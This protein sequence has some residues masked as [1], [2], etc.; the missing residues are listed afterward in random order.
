VSSACS[1][2]GFPAGWTTATPGVTYWFVTEEIKREFG[3]SY[4]MTDYQV[5]NGLVYGIYTVLSD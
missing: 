2:T 3:A 4:V 5:S 1:G